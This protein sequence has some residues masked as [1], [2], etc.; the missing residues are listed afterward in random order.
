MDRHATLLGERRA[1]PL[2]DHQM[3][4]NV[5]VLQE[6]QNADGERRSRRAG[7]ADDN[8]FHRI[9]SWVVARRGGKRAR[10]A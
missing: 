6:L 4:V 7:D 1:P 5:H 3:H 10:S 2:G 8:A 9:S